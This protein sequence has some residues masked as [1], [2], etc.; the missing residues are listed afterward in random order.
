M[1]NQFA[2]PERFRTE[3]GDALLGHA[4]TLVD[5]EPSLG[6]DPSAIRRRAPRR[7]AVRRLVPALVLA[8]AVAAAVLI[9]RSGGALGPQPATAAG[10]LNASAA[11]LD[12]YGQSRALGPHDYFYSKIAEWWR[13]AQF[14]RR[15]YVVRSVDE[16]WVARDGH[17]RS[18]Y[19]VVGLG[20]SGVNRRLPL[21]RS[22][23]R[24]LPHSA[25]PFILSP[26]PAVMFSYAQ[27][28]R[29]PTDPT[30]LAAAID[31]L[32]DRYRNDRR[33]LQLSTRT[34]VRFEILGQLAEL[35][36]S[37]RLRAALY[38]VLAQTRDIRL[39]GRG[40]DSIGRYG[41]EVAVAV[42]EAQLRLIIDPA[43]G[44]L[45]Q[46]SRTLLHRSRLYFDGKQPAGL[47]NRATFLASGIVGSSRARVP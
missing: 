35:P 20:G 10:V 7:L 45:L 16:Q 36:T 15:P 9:L 33:A 6:P 21:T 4:T 5:H 31:R 19:E 34:A 1:S 30:R 25:R 13:Y 42:G 29:L 28:R 47:I 41:M 23:D 2:A 11:K 43:T 44:E 27:L 46:A 32:A 38:R 26:A 22:Q 3:L 8:A 40:R 37:A 24:R 17:G 18:R 12:D 39:L 14:S